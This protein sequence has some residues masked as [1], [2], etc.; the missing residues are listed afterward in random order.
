MRLSGVFVVSGIGY[1]LAGKLGAQESDGCSRLSSGPRG[2][3]SPSV[4]STFKR[5][6]T[7]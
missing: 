5:S 3:G 4:H 2:G 6:K 7:H 1:G